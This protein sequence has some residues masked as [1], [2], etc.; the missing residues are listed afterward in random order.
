MTP[1]MSTDSFH[2]AC[3][4]AGARVSKIGYAQVIS[5]SAGDE[6]AIVHDADWGNHTVGHDLVH[7]NHHNDPY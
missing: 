5:K 4:R 6:I 1:Y 2:V 7:H 3:D